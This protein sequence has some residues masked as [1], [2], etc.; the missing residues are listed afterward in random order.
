MFLWNEEKSLDRFYIFTIKIL[1]KIVLGHGYT[2]A[3]SLFYD[4][5]ANNFFKNESRRDCFV[6]KSPIVS[7][8][9]KLVKLAIICLHFSFLTILH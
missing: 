4:R 7:I 1:L 8:K 2:V 9:Q 5:F 3:V 6:N